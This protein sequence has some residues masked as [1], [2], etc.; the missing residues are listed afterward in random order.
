MSKHQF[1]WWHRVHWKKCGSSV[2][3]AFFVSLTTAVGSLTFLTLPSS[4]TIRR[5]HRTSPGSKVPCCFLI[6]FYSKFCFTCCTCHLEPVTS[7][8]AIFSLTHG[9]S[10]SPNSSSR[11]STTHQPV[12]PVVPPRHCCT[13]H[14]VITIGQHQRSPSELFAAASLSIQQSFYYHYYYLLHLEL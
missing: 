2:G 9:H 5:D 4:S 7:A 8:T 10:A 13:H 1:Q 11:T 3:V 12:M 14:F 6:H